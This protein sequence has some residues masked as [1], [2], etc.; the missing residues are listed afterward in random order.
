LI[1]DYADDTNLWLATKELRH[2]EKFRRRFR[3][4]IRGL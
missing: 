2:E 4:K 3:G 1:A